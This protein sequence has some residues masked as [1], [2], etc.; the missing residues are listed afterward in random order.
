MIRAAMAAI[1]EQVHPDV[2][3]LPGLDAKVEARLAEHAMPQQLPPVLPA[4]PH[5]INTGRAEVV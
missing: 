4:N 3:S 2:V 1:A 5:S